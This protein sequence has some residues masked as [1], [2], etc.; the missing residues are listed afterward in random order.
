MK[1]EIQIY[2]YPNNTIK[3]VI[4]NY[5]EGLY[6][7]SGEYKEFNSLLKQATEIL[8][9]DLINTMKEKEP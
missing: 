7:V 8:I 9:H 2:T 3:L 1:I 4:T 5:G 6:M